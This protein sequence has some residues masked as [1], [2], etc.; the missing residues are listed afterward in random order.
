MR[1]MLFPEWDK[2][3]IEYIQSRVIGLVWLRVEFR[4]NSEN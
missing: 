4:K 1:R 3:K 2:K